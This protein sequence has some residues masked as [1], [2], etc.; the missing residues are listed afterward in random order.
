MSVY[1]E[2][3]AVPEA[4]D[5]LISRG[6]LENSRNCS[7]ENPLCFINPFSRDV[8]MYSFE[9]KV[10]WYYTYTIKYVIVM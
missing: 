5:E 6:S 7:Y 9:E 4:S 10:H 1:T 2:G 3:D 8:D